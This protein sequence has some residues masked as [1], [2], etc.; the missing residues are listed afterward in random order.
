[1]NES[2]LADL[3]NRH[4]DA[5]QSGAALHGGGE[6]PEAVRQA[7]KMAGKVSRADFSAD[8]RARDALRSRREG[9]RRGRETPGRPRPGATRPLHDRR[10]GSSWL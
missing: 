6:T 10:T 7:L 9:V 1:M 4:W 5:S 8:S 2:E 3:F